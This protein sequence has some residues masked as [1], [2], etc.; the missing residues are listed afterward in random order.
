MFLRTPW[1]LYSSYTRPLSSH[2][3]MSVFLYSYTFLYLQATSILLFF[4]PTCPRCS[5]RHNFFYLYNIYWT[6]SLSYIPNIFTY[7]I[8]YQLFLAPSI[9]SPIYTG[10]I[11]WNSFMLLTPFIILVFNITNGLPFFP[12]FH[13]SFSFKSPVLAAARTGR[14]KK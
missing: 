8:F 13:Y 4:S 11:T 2:Y 3:Y 12:H 14:G 10:H 7:L 1:I 5:S 9:G 6:L